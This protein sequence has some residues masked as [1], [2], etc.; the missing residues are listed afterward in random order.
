MCR[1]RFSTYYNLK[2]ATLLLCLAFFVWGT[3]PMQKYLLTMFPVKMETSS[4]PSNT[5]MQLKVD[6][7]C[8]YGDEAV[9]APLIERGKHNSNYNIFFILLSTFTGLFTF[10][11]RKTPF[12]F[13]KDR[14]PFSPVPLFLRNQVLII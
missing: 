2:A 1:N 12:S 10:V 4:Q 8:S 3:C 6:S 9:K 5:A 7:T 14:D 11:F 13:V